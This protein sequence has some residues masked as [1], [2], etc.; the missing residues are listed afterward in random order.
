MIVAMK[1]ILLLMPHAQNQKALEVLGALG[2]VHIEN[3][4]VPSSS[5]LNTVNER[6]GLLEQARSVLASLNSLSLPNSSPNKFSDPL[7]FAQHIVDLQK[8][9]DQLKEYSV[10]LNN[11]IDAWKDWG[12]FDPQQIKTLEEKNIWLRLYQIPKEQIKNLP[13]TVVLKIISKQGDL[14]NCL[15]ISLHDQDFGFKKLELP[16]MSL[17]QMRL[18]LAEDRQIMDLI[19]QDLLTD[20]NFQEDLVVFENT[21]LKQKEFYSYLGGMG[22]AGDLVYLR[23]FIPFDA[24]ESLVRNS[25]AN[26]WGILTLEPSVDDLV[27]TLV[28]NPAWIK[29]IQPVL[30]LLELVPGY[31]ELDISMLFLVFFSFFFGLLFVVPDYGLC[32]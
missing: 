13:A 9:Y 5:Q 15:V 27:P 4:I 11:W 1:K 24:E 19:R 25:K 2:V 6:L 26:G 32:Y 8:R 30:K 7:I 18:R 12:D 10:S 14:I 16:K 28:R 21:L 22:Q 20:L 29:L 23:G 3:E 31:E 17:V